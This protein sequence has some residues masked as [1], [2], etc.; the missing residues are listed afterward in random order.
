[1]K[2]I[3]TFIFCIL[4][5]FIIQLG[6][7]IIIEIGLFPPSEEG[8]GRIM[9]HISICIISVVFAYYFQDIAE[10]IYYKKLDDK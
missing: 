1:M 6:Y 3:L 5:V 7:T 2:H 9:R 4:I 10:W 8:M